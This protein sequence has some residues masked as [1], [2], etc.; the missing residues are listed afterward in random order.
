LGSPTAEYGAN[1]QALVEGKNGS[2]IRNQMGHRHIPQEEAHKIQAFYN[3]DV[4][5]L[6]EFSSPM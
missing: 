1:D 6:P 2:I 3:G 5:Y 4:Q